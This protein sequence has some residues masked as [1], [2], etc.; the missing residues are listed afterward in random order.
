M[1][2]GHCSTLGMWKAFD[3]WDEGQTSSPPR[4][5]TGASLGGDFFQFWANFEGEIALGRGELPGRR[6]EVAIGNGEPHG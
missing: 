4:A 6:Y 3:S 5:A 2:T 1:L